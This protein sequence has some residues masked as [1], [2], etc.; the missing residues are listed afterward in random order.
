MN[1]Q[2]AWHKSGTQCY[3]LKA[4]ILKYW[5][6]VVAV[7]TLGQNPVGKHKASF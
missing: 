3:L 2:K 7:S 1:K 4:D 5:F 6:V